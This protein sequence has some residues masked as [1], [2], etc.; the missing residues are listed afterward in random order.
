MNVQSVTLHLPAP[1]YQ[2][3]QKRAEK[4]QHSVEDELIQVVAIALPALDELPQETTEVLSQLRFLDDA[5]LWQAARTRMLPEQAERL[6]QLNL[7]QQHEGLTP[8]EQQERDQL[9]GHYEQ[10]MLV[11]AQAAVLLQERGHDVSD[12]NLFTTPA[13]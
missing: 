12:P 1:L 7:K 13:E 5:E 2:K 10:T 6:E 11:R 8:D 4:A 3:V 9:L